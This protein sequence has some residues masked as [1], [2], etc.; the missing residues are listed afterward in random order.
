MTY[1]V[2][3]NFPAVHLHGLLIYEGTTPQEQYFLQ[4]WG[5]CI[6][7]PLVDLHFKFH[8][9]H[10]LYVVINLLWKKILNYFFFVGS[11]IL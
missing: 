6:P 3:F 8:D 9:M 11:E 1:H 5:I 7:D 4:N 10:R 2:P